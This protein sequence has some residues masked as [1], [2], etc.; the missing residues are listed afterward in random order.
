MARKVNSLAGWSSWQ[1]SALSLFKDVFGVGCSPWSFS[2]RPLTSAQYLFGFGSVFTD[3]WRCLFQ[4]FL[5]RCWAAVLYRS[6]TDFLL[7]LGHIRRDFKS[8]NGFVVNA[9][10]RLNHLPSFTWRLTSRKLIMKLYLGEI[11]I[12][13]RLWLKQTYVEHWTPA[14]QLISLTST[15]FFWM[16]GFPT[17]TVNKNGKF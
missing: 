7:S 10:S 12:G 2:G 1:Q 9:D 13:L 4:V 14:K 17:L 16:L 5:H 6:D 3:S 15:L 8:L 11:R